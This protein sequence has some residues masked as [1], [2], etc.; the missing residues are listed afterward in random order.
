MVDWL[1]E[2]SPLESAFGRVVDGDEGRGGGSADMGSVG[3]DERRVRLGP[4]SASGVG[5]GAGVST[6]ILSLSVLEPAVA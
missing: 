2:P 1:A 5:I 4:A 3:G 6:S